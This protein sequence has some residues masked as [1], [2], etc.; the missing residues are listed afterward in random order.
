MVIAGESAAA[1]VDDRGR[2]TERWV[3]TTRRAAGPAKERLSLEWEPSRQ[4]QQVRTGIKGISR[5]YLT[6][7]LYWG[8]F[9]DKLRLIRK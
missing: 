9:R 3:M 6:N 1:D 7:Q 8:K 4:P 5:L 2:S